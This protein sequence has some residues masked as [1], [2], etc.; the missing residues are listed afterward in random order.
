MLRLPLRQAASLKLESSTAICLG[1]K[2]WKSRGRSNRAAVSGSASVLSSFTSGS[3]QTSRRHR[4]LIRRCW[5]ALGI[6]TTRA[7]DRRRGYEFAMG[8]VAA[9]SPTFLYDRPVGKPDRAARSRVTLRR[10]FNITMSL[11]AEE[12]FFA[13]QAQ[14]Q[15]VGP[16]PR[17][18]DGLV[19]RT[20]S[21]G[22]PPKRRRVCLS[23]HA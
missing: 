4:R 14:F 12:R 19:R 22:A 10:V 23:R 9:W 3:T 11:P 18:R 17:C 1:W 15:V 2:N 8:R 16:Y 5:S 6:S 20:P 21:A 7:S 13:V